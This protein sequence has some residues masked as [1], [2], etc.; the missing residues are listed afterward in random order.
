M[1]EPE[2]FIYPARPDACWKGYTPALIKPPRA[3]ESVPCSFCVCSCVSGSELVW[4][5]AVWVRDGGCKRIRSWLFERAVSMDS[6][7]SRSTELPEAVRRGCGI[8]NVGESK[9]PSPLSIWLADMS[10]PTGE[11]GACSDEVTNDSDDSCADGERGDL[12]PRRAPE[13]E[14]RLAA[15]TLLRP[16]S[17]LVR[18]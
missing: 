6:L 15:L 2:L 18:L 7:R 8:F 10:A 5:S 11:L 12:S 14:T 1:R 17:K 16:L 4:W 9:A 3:V 13:K